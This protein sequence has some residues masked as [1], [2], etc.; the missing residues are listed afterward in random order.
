MA[1]ERH[2]YP[3]RIAEIELNDSAAVCVEQIDDE[4]TVSI[5]SVVGV[6]FQVTADQAL[7]LSRALAVAADNAVKSRVSVET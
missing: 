7:E 6:H 3:G 2:D 4:I 1:D 5:A